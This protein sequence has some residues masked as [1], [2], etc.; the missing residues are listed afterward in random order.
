[1]IELEALPKEDKERRRLEGLKA[2]LAYSYRSLATRCLEAGEPQGG[3]E[4]LVQAEKHAGPSARE[5]RP[6]IEEIRAKI[7][8]GMGKNQEALES[9]TR[10]F[11]VQMS[12]AIRDK[13]QTLA[14]K[15]GK[16]AGD[17]FNRARELRQ[18]SA[19][20][21]KPFALKTDDGRPASL[22]SLKGKVTL[23]NF[24]FPT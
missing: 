6:S 14:L 8:A 12:P 20:P 7:Y 18:A 15:T 16:P 22:E 13:I 24:F 2:G 23:V 3:L 1:V 4:A 17:Y 21:F 10:S 5:L 9:Y 11:S 19:E